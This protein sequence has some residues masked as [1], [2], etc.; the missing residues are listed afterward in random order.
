MY[1]YSSLAILNLASKH[2]L[3]FV[4]L[5]YSKKVHDLVK[6]LNNLGYLYTYS[7]D[8]NSIIVF[9]RKYNNIFVFNG[10]FFYSKPGHI[11]SITIDQLR[12]EYYKKN[13]LF[14]LSTIN[15]ICTSK[16]ALQKH[17]GGIILAEINK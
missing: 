4:K 17:I 11:Y 9:F 5:P 15:G 10:F 12:R 6:L 16:E 7:L 13:R 2:K 14:I 3:N 8:H 1:L